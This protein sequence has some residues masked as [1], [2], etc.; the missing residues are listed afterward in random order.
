MCVACQARARRC[1]VRDMRHTS[2][3]V[4]RRS[5]RCSLSDGRSGSC[6]RPGSQNDSASN[7]PR[8]VSPAHVVS[9]TFRA[10]RAMTAATEGC[11]KPRVKAR[12]AAQWRPAGNG[13]SALQ[14]C[15]KREPRAVPRVGQGSAQRVGRADG[16]HLPQ[17]CD[18]RRRCARQ[19]DRRLRHSE[20][21]AAA[22]AVG[23]TRLGY[24]RGVADSAANAG[25][26]AWPACAGR[27]GDRW[28]GARGRRPERV[29]EDALMP[30]RARDAVS[31]P[32]QRIQRK[33]RSK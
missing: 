25:R 24:G 7:L 27:R 17:R 23:R 9:S 21:R 5:P 6:S 29:G 10:Q 30:A 33:K 14:Y 31:G 13:T 26:G 3:S 22:A 16:H 18:G 19:P 28:R 32:G 8:H 12:K 1:A 2:S 11:A 15:R 4:A 20:W